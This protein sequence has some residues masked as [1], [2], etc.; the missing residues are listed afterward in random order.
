M[1]KNNVN[2]QI[3]FVSFPQSRQQ[4]ENERETILE[5]FHYHLSSWGS[6]VALQQQQDQVW[7]NLPDSRVHTSRFNHSS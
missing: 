4:C 2:R 5:E 1:P 3:S 6:W 7:W